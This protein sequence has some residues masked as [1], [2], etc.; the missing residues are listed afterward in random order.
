VQT[1]EPKIKEFSGEEFTRITFCPD[2]AKFNM[3]KL[4]D[5]HLA[6]MSRRYLAVR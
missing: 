2:L 3:E 6:L 4:D 5:D 1:T